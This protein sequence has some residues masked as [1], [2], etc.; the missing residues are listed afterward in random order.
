MLMADYNQ[1]RLL[2]EDKFA[3]YKAPARSIP[4]SIGHHAEWI[5]ACKTGSPTTCHFGYSGPL[6]ETVLLGNVAYRV[7]EKLQWDAAKLKAVGTDKA[8]QFLKREYR[9][10]WSL[11]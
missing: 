8:D 6:T 2:P 5:Q 9:K 10:G 1:H 11:G 3:G 7:G 4:P